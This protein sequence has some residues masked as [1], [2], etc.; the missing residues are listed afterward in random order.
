M[1][2]SLDTDCANRDSYQGTQHLS[3]TN[4]SCAAIDK[5][6]QLH[7]LSALQ[8]KEDTTHRPELH[9][10]GPPRTLKTVSVTVLRRWRDSVTKAT[11]PWEKS[12]NCAG[13]T[14]ADKT[15]LVLM[16]ELRTTGPSRGFWNLKASLQWHT[17]F[18]SAISSNPSS[19]FKEF[20]SVVTKHSGIWVNRR[21]SY[22]NHHKG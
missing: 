22:S 16:R 20:H 2:N 7:W 12:F 18:N 4:L 8:S 9:L 14:V 15:G 10:L 19:L 5:D 17:S 11:I 6:H 3:L 13:S 1:S 21:H